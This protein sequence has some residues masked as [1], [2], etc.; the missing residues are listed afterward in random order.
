MKVL[1]P[2]IQLRAQLTGELATAC[3]KFRLKQKGLS[4]PSHLRSLLLAFLQP[5]LP[6]E[7]GV[8]PLSVPI[9]VP[10]PCSRTPE[11]Q[12]Q[13]AQCMC[14]HLP[15]FCCRKWERAGILSPWG[16]LTGARTGRVLNSSLAVLVMIDVYFIGIY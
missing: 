12:S 14:E 10:K 9:P 11:F 15:R 7:Q 2:Q 3:P 4:P 1:K 5:L 13:I 6:T 16:H 8:R